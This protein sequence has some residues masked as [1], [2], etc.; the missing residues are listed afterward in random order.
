MLLLMGD[1]FSAQ[2]AGLHSIRMCKQTMQKLPVATLGTL[3][4]RRLRRTLRSA[5]WVILFVARAIEWGVFIATLVSV[6]SIVPRHCAHLISFVYPQLKNINAVLIAPQLMRCTGSIPC[7]KTEDSAVEFQ[8]CIRCTAT[9]LAH[10]P[11]GIS[12]FT[13]NAAC[14]NVIEEP[15]VVTLSLC[16]LELCNVRVV[17]NLWQCGALRAL[18]SDTPQCHLCSTW[19]SNK[20]NMTHIDPLP[21]RYFDVPMNISSTVVECSSSVLSVRVCVSR[22]LVSRQLWVWV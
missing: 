13:A 20:A 9:V 1:L 15:F 8:Y 17:H 2:S 3:I 14:G 5:V 18:C 6:L 12:C 22:L 21:T 10:L 11:Q 19:Q 16:S 4:L 7:A